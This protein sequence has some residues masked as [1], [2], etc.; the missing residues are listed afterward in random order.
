MD[1]L[2]TSLR[3]LQPSSSAFNPSNSFATIHQSFLRHQ[4][5]PTIKKGRWQGTTE[6]NSSNNQLTSG[7]L[8]SYR[9]NKNSNKPFTKAIIEEVTKE[10]FFTKDSKMYKNN[11]DNASETSANDF[12]L[13]KRKRA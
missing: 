6:E 8:L 3:I 5:N 4:T 2:S 10:H 7:K 9:S 11:N 13:K 1:A 12:N